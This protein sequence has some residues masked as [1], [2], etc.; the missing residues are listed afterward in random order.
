M[1]KKMDQQCHCEGGPLLA[2][3]GKQGADCGNLKPRNTKTVYFLRSIAAG[4]TTVISSAAE[5]GVEKS[6]KQFLHLY[7]FS[8]CRVSLA[9]YRI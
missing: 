5:G 2:F 3:A 6:I 4:N 8:A 7:S 9:L 1:Q